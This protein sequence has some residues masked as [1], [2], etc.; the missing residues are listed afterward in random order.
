MQGF[1]NMCTNFRIVI[2]VVLKSTSKRFAWQA[3]T[4]NTTQGHLLCSLNLP[5]RE[6]RETIS[7]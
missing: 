1:V 5:H 2:D 4:D 6:P 7:I 3:P